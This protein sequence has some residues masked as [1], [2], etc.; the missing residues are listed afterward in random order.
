MHMKKYE[1]AIMK[2]YKKRQ[3]P[4]LEAA[5]YCCSFLLSIRQ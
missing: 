3:L 2:M 1:L 5:R 4:W